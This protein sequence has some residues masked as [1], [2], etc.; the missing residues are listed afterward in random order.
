M[1]A[2][3]N[4]GLF[5]LLLLAGSSNMLAD[6]II[7]ETFTDYPDNALISVSPAGPAVGLRDDWQLDAEN[8]FYVN[9]TE[10]DLES[11]T[12]KAVYDFP[13]DDNGARTASRST[14]IDHVLFSDDGD[15]FYASF[16]IEPAREMGHMFFILILDRLDGGGQPEISFGMKDGQFVVGNGGVEVDIGG[17]FPTVTEML[18]VLKVEYGA[19]GSEVVTLWADPE[20]ESSDPVIDSELVNFLNQGGGKVTAVAIRGEQMAGQPALFDD[21]RVGLK[22]EDVASDVQLPVLSPDVGVNGMFYDPSNPGHGLDFN[23]H[24]LGFTVFY[25]GHTS[26]G[27]RLW[28]HSE[29]FNEDLEFG[30][31]YELEMFEAI[32][33]VFGNPAIPVTTWGTITINLTD[34]DSGH[35]SFSGIDGNLEMDLA[36]LTRLPGIGCH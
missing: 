19:G 23:V 4:T 12:G 30:L 20:N 18:V 34:C 31:S 1:Y 36:R 13:F 10:A 27:E 2:K 29:L 22:F 21:L 11:G 3:F 14:S 7:F 6:P 32:N 33:G 28:L 24:E 17:G 26:N 9:R 25:Y 15:V 35:A 5:C 8:N 16:L